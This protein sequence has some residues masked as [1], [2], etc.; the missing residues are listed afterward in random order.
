MFRRINFDECRSEQRNSEE[1]C[2]IG[3]NRHCISPRCIS[4]AKII[5]AGI[6]KDVRWSFS[7]TDVAASEPKDA[8]EFE[9]VVK[10]LT[11]GQ[12]GKSGRRIPTC[13]DYGIMLSIK[14]E[15]IW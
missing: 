15:R 2:L 8:G 12:L 10:F 13:R 6:A 14:E 11:R 3:P 5:Q 7:F 9:F 1:S 4:H